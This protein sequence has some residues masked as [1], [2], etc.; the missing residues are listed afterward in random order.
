MDQGEYSS[1]WRRF[2]SNNC[3]RTVVWR[4]VSRRIQLH[5]VAL[6]D[7][8]V[9]H[10]ACKSWPTAALAQFPSNKRH[11][12]VKHWNPESQATLRRMQCKTLSTTSGATIPT[13]KAPPPSNA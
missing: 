2:K 9:S 6:I 4:F 13:S 10:A 7:A 5:D 12:R 11:A 3:C 1:F 8:Q